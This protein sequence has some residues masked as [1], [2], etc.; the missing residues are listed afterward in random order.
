MTISIDNTGSRLVNKIP[1]ADVTL[2]L[3]PSSQENLSFDKIEVDAERFASAEMKKQLTE[4]LT[5]K[6]F[7]QMIAEAIQ[8]NLEEYKS[9]K[10]KIIGGVRFKFTDKG[11]LIITLLR[12]ENNA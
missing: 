7:N 4:M 6:P 10:E 5:L 2:H 3:T 11:E 9:V 1:K 12:K 8:I